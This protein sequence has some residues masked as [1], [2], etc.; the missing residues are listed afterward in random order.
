MG[1]ATFHFQENF[2]DGKLLLYIP[3]DCQPARFYGGS[4]REQNVHSLQRSHDHMSASPLSKRRTFCARG[5]Y[6]LD[7]ERQVH[8]FFFRSSK[9]CS[10]GEEANTLA[11][12]EAKQ[13]VDS[14]RLDFDR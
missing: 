12:E 10:T 8:G 5:E 11:I 2:M 3:K 1:T 7:N 4:F 14:R 9:E 13:W 6:Q